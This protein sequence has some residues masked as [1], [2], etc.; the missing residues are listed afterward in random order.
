[1]ISGLFNT[2]KNAAAATEACRSVVEEVRNV[3]T[4]NSSQPPEDRKICF[5][6][7]SQLSSLVK[8][9][10]FKS[11]SIYSNKEETLFYIVYVQRF[12]AL[13]VMSNRN[14]ALRKQ[15]ILNGLFRLIEILDVLEPNTFLN[16]VACLLISIEKNATYRE[17]HHACS[18]GFDDVVENFCLNSSI[19]PIVV[20]N[21]ATVDGLLPLQIAANNDNYN[22]VIKLLE[23]GA[24]I[25]KLDLHMRNV[26][27]YAAK[28]SPSILRLLMSYDR[29][30]QA[31]NRFDSDGLSPLCLAMKSGHV[32]CAKILLESGCSR[33][34]FPAGP[35]CKIFLSVPV[36]TEGFINLLLKYEPNFLCEPI[37]DGSSILH[38]DLDAPLL[39][40]IMSKV[41]KEVKDS[42]DKNKRTPLHRS[43][44]RSNLS[45][46]LALL[47][48]EVNVDALDENG[49]TPLNIAVQIGSLELVKCLLCFGASVTLLNNGGLR[50]IDIA[51]KSSNAFRLGLKEILI[52]IEE[53]LGSSVIEYFDWLAGTSTGAIIALALAR[54][55]SPRSCQGLYIRLKSEVFIGEKPYSD[56][57]FEQI[58][59]RYFGD[60]LV[61]AHIESKKIMITATSVKT[62]VPQLKLF[63]N[64]RLPLSEINNQVLG[65]DDPSNLLVWKCARYSSAAPTYF[66]PKDDYVDGGLVAN[67][68]TLDLLSDIHEYNATH[69]QANMEKADIN[70]I[71]SLGT[72][73][74]P[75]K[76]IKLGKLEF[77]IPQNLEEGQ[78]MLTDF[79]NMKSILI[80]QITASD[81][82]CVR[83]ARSWAHGLN[84]PFFRLSPPLST[85][86]QLDE[87][88]NEIIIEFLWET[89]RYLRTIA[90][91]DIDSLVKLLKG[92]I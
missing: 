68:P 15:K 71:V 56:K 17:I 86:V 70:C 14:E 75:A 85:D 42:E 2:I 28:K 29:S 54:G 34:P 3:I 91:S 18:C 51:K 19:D 53:K 50:P 4:W 45:Q 66:A 62:N 8:C 35:L 72:G 30:Q 55:D 63:R 84:I 37:C 46:T 90:H 82:E 69:A 77:G 67:N 10:D 74:L 80:K 89:E 41:T 13:S 24:D 40:L 12:V 88:E 38:Q 26:F 23:Y 58:L 76:K 43:V 7:T 78:S 5:L 83:R 1:M 49:D 73:V 81:G 27:H 79:L 61:M 59:K 57:E 36:D 16:R 39:I 21:K 31:M 22:V 65:Y 25:H 9:D 64:Y 87:K 48:F 44:Q 52:H 6:S 20:V 33:G 11:V 32:E 47:S 60:S 92:D